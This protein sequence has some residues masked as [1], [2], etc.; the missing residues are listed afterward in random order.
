MEGHCGEST[1]E[2]IARE[3]PDPREL[4][5]MIV[6]LGF[7]VADLLEILRQWEPDHASAEHLR[8]IWFARC[9]LKDANA[10]LTGNPMEGA[11]PVEKAGDVRR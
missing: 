2:R 10:L 7:R 9:A 6:R 8:L 4:E 5:Q 11:G 3:R 1:S